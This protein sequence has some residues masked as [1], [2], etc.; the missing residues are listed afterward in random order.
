M[1]VHFLVTVPF[2]VGAILLVLKLLVAGNS[3]KGP[4]GPMIRREITAPDGRKAVFVVPTREPASVFIARMYPNGVIPT[5]AAQGT[6][7]QDRP[8]LAVSSAP[9]PQALSPAQQWFWIGLAGFVVV[10]FLLS[11]AGSQ[12]DRGP[13]MTAVPPSYQ[14]ASALTGSVRTSAPVLPRVQLKT[15]ANVRNGPSRSAAILRVGQQGEVFTKFNEANGWFQVG[16]AQ[17][18]GWVAQSVATLV[19]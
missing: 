13:G 1:H 8:R 2:W 11:I 5:E 18:E 4:K 19:P 12:S 15:G 17:P 14:T 7:H 6:A 10:V 9:R 3:A 16:T